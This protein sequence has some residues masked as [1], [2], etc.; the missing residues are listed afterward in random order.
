MVL[1]SLLPHK[2]YFV[3]KRTRL[4]TVISYQ[5]SHVDLDHKRNVLPIEVGDSDS[6]IFHHYTVH[7]R[8][9]YAKAYPKVYHARTRYETRGNDRREYFSAFRASS[10][11][12]LKDT[13]SDISAIESFRTVHCLL[14]TEV[15]I[16]RRKSKED[17]LF[18]NP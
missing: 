16:S 13:P 18:L 12:A 7:I 15:E 2:P 10:E 11:G 9:C 4:K 6:K 8:R 1:N 17:S 14:I 5:V 3:P